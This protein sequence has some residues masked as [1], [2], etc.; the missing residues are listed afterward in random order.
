VSNLDV[1]R[2]HGYTALEQAAGWLRFKWLLPVLVAIAL[3]LAFV[4]WSWS[5]IDLD[6][7]STPFIYAIF[8]SIF[9]SA[10]PAVICF[11]QNVSRRRQLSKLMSLA[12]YPVGNTVYFQ[13]AARNV[14]SIRLVMDADYAVPIFLLFII[15]CAGFLAILIAFSHPALF[16]VASVLLG[17]IQDQTD[18]SAFALYQK[19][20]FAIVAFAFLGSYVYAIGRILDRINNGD[21]Y[22]ISIYY[23]IAR[24]IIACAAAAVLRHT[25]GVFGDASN[26]FL[27]QGVSKD[28]API[29]LL[30][31]FAIGFSPDLFILAIVRKAF[32]AMKVWGA[33]ADPPEDVRPTSLPLLM[34]DDLSRD[35]VDRLN[36]LEIDSAQAL[37]QQNPFMLLPRLPYDLGLLVDWIAQ[38]QLY[39]L[40]RDAKLKALRDI[41]VHDAFELEV[42]LADDQARP[43]ACTALGLPEAAAAALLHQLQRN[44][45]YVRLREVKDAMLLL[46]TD[47]DPSG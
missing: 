6:T 22:P 24:V 8:L 5:R 1:S 15:N 18:A 30:I 13:V 29:M 16:N 26:S 19:Q 45:A 17:G 37:A 10:L 7:T 35:K 42:R 44:A 14:D 9:F 33:R 12:S 46:T 39:V 32:Q 40:V 27:P 11:V 43:G 25:L 4:T 47:D 38:A 31:G 34:I 2:S 28:A 21:L 20:T 23:Y 36:E 41:L 3:F